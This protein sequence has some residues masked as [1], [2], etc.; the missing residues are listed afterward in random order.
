MKYSVDGNSRWSGLYDK[1]TGDGRM[2]EDQ[3]AQMPKTILST[4]RGKNPID[5]EKKSFG[6]LGDE[7]AYKK[8]PHEHWSVRCGDKGVVKWRD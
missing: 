8:L 6:N 4:Y 3:L 2:K 5:S 1:S 7:K